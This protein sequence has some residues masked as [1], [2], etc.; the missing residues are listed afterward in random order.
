MNDRWAVDLAKMMK[1]DA[2]NEALLLGTVTGLDPLEITMNN[3][4]VTRNLYVNPG[5]MMSAADIDYYL[6]SLIDQMP[7][8]AVQGLK[9]VLKENVLKLHDRVVVMKVGIADFY[10]LQRMVKV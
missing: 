6:R 5:M 4:P 8:E 7:D 1:G 10:V 2:G 9:T 3:V